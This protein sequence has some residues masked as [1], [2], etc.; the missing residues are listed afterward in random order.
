MAIITALLTSQTAV[1]VGARAESPSTSAPA[2]APA[3]A[4]VLPG[5]VGPTELTK[6]DKRIAQLHAALQITTDEEV[7]WREFADVMRNNTRERNRSQQQREA[8]LANLNAMENMESFVQVARE[9]AEELQRLATAF[10]ALYAAMPDE[11]KKVADQV[12]RNIAAK[13][14]LE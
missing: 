8:Q 10:Q 9:H 5:A 11:Q 14:A 4:E 2:P 13:R 6:V 7:Q 12:L 3:P 1:P